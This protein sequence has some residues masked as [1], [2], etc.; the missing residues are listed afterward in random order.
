MSDSNNHIK[1]YT[2]QDIERYLNRQMPAREMHALE[3]AALDDPFLAEAI[4]GYVNTPP[5]SVAN[6]I[7]AMVKELEKKTGTKVV[8][9]NFKRTAWSAAAAVIILLGTATT[10]FWLRPST[11]NSIV[12]HKEE[13]SLP[14]VAP[15][16]QQDNLKTVTDTA[17]A[18]KLSVEKEPVVVSSPERK[19]ADAPLVLKEQQSEAANPVQKD[20]AGE[21]QGF[22]KNKTQAALEDK[23]PGL[24]SR[25]PE[26]LPV[27][28]QRKTESKQGD[29]VVATQQVED[30]KSVTGYFAPY[31]FSGTIKDNNN[32]PLPFV[33]I[34]IANTP[35][36]TYSD[37]QGNFRLTS[38]DSQLVVH[39]K[40][41]GFEEK[42]IAL[43]S[44]KPVNAIQLQP[45]ANALDE[46]VVVGYGSQKK[47]TIT[48]SKEMKKQESDKEEE[49]P[50]AEPKDGWAAYDAYM[51]NNTKP[52]F[53]N[54]GSSLKG[55]VELSFTVSKYGM[56]TD[57][58]IERS[59]CT[60]CNNEAIRL[61][62][63]GPQWKLLSG[64]KPARVTLTMY[65]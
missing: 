5:A 4:E 61:I 50:E 47:R 35:A 1:T 2:A 41:V 63:E 36:S 43:S 16:V 42:E 10:W 38:A 65:F 19:K 26:N 11:E 8:G 37:A 53:S 33:N 29:V 17:R 57:F 52:P 32:K 23:V 44:A 20:N 13:K 62:K 3:K 28:Q 21:K 9:M 27:T 22:A 7:A 6:D 48:G 25:K 31:I 56:L 39:L 49:E 54:P 12:Q 24:Q 45:N 55:S 34:S 51:M 40:S 59:S 15:P 30:M 14:A 46:V 60:L 18:S 58:R 64:E